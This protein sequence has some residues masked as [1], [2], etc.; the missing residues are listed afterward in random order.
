[1]RV[2]VEKQTNEIHHTKLTIVSFPYT[3]QPSMTH[4]T[5]LEAATEP[6]KNDY[7]ESLCMNIGEGKNGVQDR[8]RW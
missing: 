7:S 8:A 3:D 1:M 2:Y 6:I 5:K 4:G